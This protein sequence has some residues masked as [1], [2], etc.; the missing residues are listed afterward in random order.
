MKNFFETMLLSAG[1]PYRKDRRPCLPGGSDAGGKPFRTAEP[2]LRYFTLIELLVV[3]AIIAI[4]A[5]MLLPALNKARQRA[6][7]ATCLSQL[8]QCGV[9]LESYSSDNNGFII[10]KI[11]AGDGKTDIDWNNALLGWKCYYDVARYP[12]RNSFSKWGFVGYLSG[13]ESL[14]W[15]PTMKD[16]THRSQFGYGMAEILYGNNWNTIKD[17]IGMIPHRHNDDGNYKYYAVKRLKRP[18]STILVAD[19]GYEFSNGY[20]G[21]CSK[22]FKH[23]EKSGENYQRGVMLRHAGRANVLYGDGHAN[24][25]NRGGLAKSANRITYTLDP[26]GVVL[27]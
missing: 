19:S 3:I 26:N 15:C 24:A 7:A 2:L 9:A 23:K 10:Q 12:D 1:L 16:D 11:K 25:L 27:R 17:D 5:A 4:L 13:P 20:A 22:A 18:S 21:F 8:K 6:Q 14:T